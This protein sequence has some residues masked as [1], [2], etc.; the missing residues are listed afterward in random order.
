M[1]E[2]LQGGNS[3]LVGLGEW[4]QCSSDQDNPR[5]QLMSYRH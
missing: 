3:D 1:K 4:C 2:F 5:P